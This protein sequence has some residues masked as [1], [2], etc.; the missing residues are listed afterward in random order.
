MDIKKREFDFE[1]KETYTK[2]ELNSILEQHTTF[3]GNGYK[4]TV[5][6]ID[7]DKVNTEL[8]TMKSDVRKATIIKSASG[9]V[10][11]DKVDALIKLSTFTEG[12]D[13]ATTLSQTLKENA[14]LGAAATPQSIE[15][16]SSIKPA[17][18]KPIEKPVVNK[19]VVDF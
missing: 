14:F 11:A 7:F 18:A 1:A 13:I 12:V 15:V 8:G 6:K 3:V 17:I 19:Y 10:T 2:D 16:R 4:D 5:S 9:L